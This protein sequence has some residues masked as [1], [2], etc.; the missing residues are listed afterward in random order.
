MKRYRMKTEG[1]IIYDPDGDPIACTEVVPRECERGSWVK[2]E[3]VEALV[4]ENEKLRTQ[5]SEY[6][7]MVNP[8]RMGG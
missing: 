8:D 3:D 6:G 5:N 2:W 1:R 4:R 7:W